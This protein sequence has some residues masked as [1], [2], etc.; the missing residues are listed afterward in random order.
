MTYRSKLSRS[1]DDFVV[2]IPSGLVKELKLKDEETLLVSIDNG[3]IVIK[4]ERI[5]KL[6]ELLRDI[7]PDN[8][9]KEIDW[10]ERE[11]NE[12]W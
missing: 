7:K 1:G 11:G 9:H 8:I 2:K 12:I 3:E 10:G 6:G 4:P 5:D